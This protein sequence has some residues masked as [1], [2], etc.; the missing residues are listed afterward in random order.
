ME[1]ELERRW[2]VIR[3]REKIDPHWSTRF[4]GMNLRHEEG[5]TVL[6]G[7]LPDRRALHT[8]LAVTYNLGLNLISVEEQEPVPDDL[9]PT[10]ASR[11]RTSSRHHS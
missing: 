4:G 5:G 8:V 11:K 6:R 3:I 2:F 9:A 10:T 7:S 1:N